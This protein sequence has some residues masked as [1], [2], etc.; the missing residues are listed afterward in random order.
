MAA[1]CAG[2]QN[3]KRTRQIRNK[4]EN[5]IPQALGI[6]SNSAFTPH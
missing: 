2:Y 5:R 4:G 3:P 1:L 6:N